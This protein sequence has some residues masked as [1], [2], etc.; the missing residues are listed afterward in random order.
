[1]EKQRF[2]LYRR[3]GIYYLHDSQTRKRESLNTRNRRKAEQIR[4]ARNEVS[5]RPQVGMALA[6]AYLTA[7]D[8]EVLKRTWQQVIGEFCSR[9][10]P[11]SNRAT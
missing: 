8:P 9:G 6:K 4:L 5:D 7:Q 2:W 3:E 1:M 10:N 11:S